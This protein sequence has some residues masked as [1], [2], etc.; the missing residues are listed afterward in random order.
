L[1]FGHEFD[2]D[3]PK[4]VDK[5][6]RYYRRL[7]SEMINTKSQKNAINLQA[8]TEFTTIICKNSKCKT[9]YNYKLLNLKIF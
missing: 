1:E 5:E 6:K 8:D 3:N 4:I 9:T 2:W 7:I